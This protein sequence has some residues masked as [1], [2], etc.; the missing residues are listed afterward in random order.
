MLHSNQSSNF[1]KKTVTEQT[2]SSIGGYVYGV[3]FKTS[4]T[5]TVEAL[6]I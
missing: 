5:S 3:K 2:S 4:W 6:D 1:N